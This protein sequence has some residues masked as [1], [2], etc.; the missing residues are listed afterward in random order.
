MR[1]EIKN[2]QGEKLD[3]KYHRAI[4]KSKRVPKK[5][6]RPQLLV[7]GH[8][9][10][11]NLDRPVV[12]ALATAAAK[13]GVHALHFSF[14]GNGESEG[15]F[16]EATISKAV[17]DLGSV[18]DACDDAGYDVSYAGHSMGA[19]TGLIRATED[20]RIK[21]VICIAPMIHTRRFVDKE[22]GELTPGKANMWGQ[23]GCRITNQFVEDLKAVDTVLPRASDLEVPLYIIHDIDDELVPWA[24]ARAAFDFAKEPKKLVQMSGAGHTFE[25]KSG[26]VM[27]KAVVKWLKE[28]H[29]DQRRVRPK[30]KVAA[31][32]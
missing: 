4:T 31:T 23:A 6:E 13:S 9:V 24:E 5:D 1:R 14:S 32:L 21:N 25:G 17:D 7:I 8:G 29:K 11:G 2:A 3:Y 20:D 30:K 18:I 28:Q 15:K 27:A 12:V 19:A 10:T 22:F 16:G 26:D